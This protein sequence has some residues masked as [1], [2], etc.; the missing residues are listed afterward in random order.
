MV[1][2][3]WFELDQFRTD[4]CKAG[5]LSQQYHS[6]SETKMFNTLKEVICAKEQFAYKRLVIYLISVLELFTLGL[7][8]K[9][10]VQNVKRKKG[11][12]RLRRRRKSGGRKR[13]QG[14]MHMGLSMRNKVFM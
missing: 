10:A 1:K 14:R 12:R 2:S 13:R 3:H 7:K 8:K 9:N 11:G 6:R 5:R 4:F